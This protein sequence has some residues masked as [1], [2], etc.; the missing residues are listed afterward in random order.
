[1]LGDI[2]ARSHEGVT[3]LQFAVCMQTP[4][5]TRWLLEN[6]AD[7]N[8]TYGPKRSTALHA[9]LRMGNLETTLAL[10]QAGADFVKDSL[11]ITPEMQV[12]PHIQADLLVV[13]P[14][15]G[16]EIPSTVYAVLKDNY[17][18]QSS[19][20]LFGA[21]VNGDLEACLSITGGASSVPKAVECGTC[22]PLIVALA[23]QRLDIAKLFLAHNAS[24]VDK[25][26]SLTRARGPCYDSVL[27]TAIAQPMFNEILE[28]LL[29]RYLT[30]EDHW[31]LDNRRWE[32]LHLCVVFNPEALTILIHHVQ[33]HVKL[34][35]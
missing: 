22:S 31:M 5:A 2:N 32:P 4:D 8:A 26:C 6:G 35:R 12:H 20:G 15:C 29:A 17:K 34:F 28:R 25:S 1:M 27:N 33:K 16:V 14:Q 30:Y 13:L 23:W 21:I 11:G 3:P 18:V 7:F 9:A 10:I 19:G 24:I